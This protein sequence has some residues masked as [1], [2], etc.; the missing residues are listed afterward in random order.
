MESTTIKSSNSS[1]TLTL[2]KKDGDYFN[3]IFDSLA[4]KSNIRVWG[5]T[6]CG[7]LVDLFKFIAKEWRGWKGKKEWFSIEGEF[8]ISA[9]SDSLGH[10]LLSLCFN[11]F[12]EPETWEVKVN[13]GIDSGQ[14]EKIAKN[15]NSFFND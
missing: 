3:V 8:C 12:N 5:Y 9:T 10:I 2:C 7:L 6:D 14:T 11:E 15:I 4:V 13:I 1:A